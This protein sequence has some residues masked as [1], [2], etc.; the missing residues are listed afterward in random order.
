[1][2]SILLITFLSSNTLAEESDW[3]WFKVDL[4]VKDS[5][6]NSG[7]AEVSKIGEAISIVF[8]NGRGDSNKVV[9]CSVRAS[10][11]GCTDKEGGVSKGFYQTRL[12]LS[13]MSDK[14]GKPR[15]RG[16]DSYLIISDD[17]LWVITK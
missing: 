10:T 6:L 11:L 15:P 1:M 2:L 13:F 3:T 9:T 17:I 12:D 4:S 14:S 8:L 5:E 16:R 7:V